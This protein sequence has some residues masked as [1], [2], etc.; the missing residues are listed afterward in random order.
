MNSF[1]EEGKMKFILEEINKVDSLYNTFKTDFSDGI[2]SIVQEYY[3]EVA[4]TDELTNLLLAY[5][6]AIINSTESVIDK[7]RNYPFYRLEE[8]LT[9]MRKIIARFDLSATYDAFT[10]QVHAKSKE[11]MVKYFA[12]I[13]DLSAT[14]FRLLEKNARVYTLEFVLSFMS[15]PK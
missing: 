9:A 5:S 12:A 10:E 13:F 14:G 11:L 2:F 15:V 4:L 3:P 7:D 8:E 6:V 1:N